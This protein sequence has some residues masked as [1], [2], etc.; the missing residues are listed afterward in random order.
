M[1]GCLSESVVEELLPALV[2]GEATDLLRELAR[3]ALQELIKFEAVTASV[4]AS[5][6][7]SV[8]SVLNEGR[9]SRSRDPEVSQRLVP[10]GDP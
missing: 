6:R 7:S 5:L 10:P 1:A 4:D 2:V 8:E 3:W 9:R